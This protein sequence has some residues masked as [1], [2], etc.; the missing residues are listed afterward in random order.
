MPKSERS[1]LQSVIGEGA[2]IEANFTRPADTTTYA[3]GDV[4]SDSTSS[5]T[6][7]TFS[8]AARISAG[9]GI[10]ISAVMTSSANETTK[11]T[12]ELWV[13]E[14]EPTAMEDNAAF[15]PTD[16]EIRD[17]IGIVEFSTWHEGLAGA[18]GNS[19]SSGSMKPDNATF[20][21]GAS[22]K[23]L[24]GILVVRNAYVPISAER[25]DFKLGVVQN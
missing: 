6:V 12:L 9:N 8:D 10:V 5:P 15:D 16:A 17:V 20:K 14:A 18:G 22:S 7:I 11:P 21:T 3:A 24:Y 19:F 23:D 4:V 1:D 13:F 2:P 25:F